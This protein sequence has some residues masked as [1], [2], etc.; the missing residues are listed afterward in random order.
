MNVYTR[1]DEHLLV[2][3]N[4][5]QWMVVDS[6][7]R[8][9]AEQLFSQKK[10]VQEIIEARSLKEREDTQT[11][12]EEIIALTNGSKD[13]TSTSRPLTSHATVAMVSLTRNCNLSCP[14][15]YVDAKGARE[16][17]LSTK[18]HESLAIEVKETLATNNHTKYQVNL[19]GGEPFMHPGVTDIISAYHK[20]GFRISM[21]TNALLIHERHLGLLRKTRTALSISLD[22]ATTDTHETIRGRGTFLPTIRKIKW[23][24]EN[25]IKVGINFLVH[26]GNIH[27]LGDTISLTHSIG[28]ASFNPI[29]LVH[30]GRACQSQL[31]RASEKDIFKIIAEHLV[32]NPDQQ[33]LFRKTSLFSSL[34]AALLGGIIFASCGVGD[35]PCVYITSEGNVFPCTNTQHNSFFLGNIRQQNLAECVNINKPVYAK[36]QQLNVDSLNCTCSQCDIR[37]FCGG[38][39]RGETYNVKGDLHAPYVHCSD[40]HDSI[41]ELMW[42]TAKHPELFEERS[43]EYIMNADRQP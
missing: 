37:Y 14:H 38:D 3:P 29:N 17:E 31:Q 16:V 15:C 6:F 22:G 13:K 4:Q 28:C 42:I 5:P 10:N 2:F 25:D 41:I 34:G 12:C 30:L 1:N 36:L 43:A 27:E 26:S 11:V 7:A 20:A 33:S 32:Q 40:R 8:D 35:R 21:S 19:T 18:E 9:V 23:L 39:C 24:V